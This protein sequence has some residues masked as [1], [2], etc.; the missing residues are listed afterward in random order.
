MTYNYY[1]EVIQDLRFY[2]N[3]KRRS[4]E[5]RKILARAISA[6]ETAN[7]E[8]KEAQSLIRKIGNITA[9][10]M[11]AFESVKKYTEANYD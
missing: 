3:D 1:D 7:L 4:I 10:A 6:L 8:L 9:D 2:A 5:Y 11:C